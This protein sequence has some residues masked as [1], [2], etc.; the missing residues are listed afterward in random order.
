VSPAGLLRLPLVAVAFLTRVP[1]GRLVVAGPDDVARAAPLFPVVGGAVGAAA[2]LTADVLAG[3]LPAQAA[4]ALAVAVAALL[5]GAM[6]LDALA[7]TADALGGATRERA[8]E[9]LRDHAIGAFGATALVV[10]LL[11]D[12]A[13]LAGLGGAG[14]AALA[15]LAA[16]AAGRAVTLP[17]AATLPSARP[18]DGQGAVLAGLRPW[19]V[20]VGIAL[21]LA[22]ALPAGAAGLAAAAAAA[23]VCV[24]LGLFYRRWLGGVTGDLLGAAAKV[25][26]T[27]ALVAAL[28]VVR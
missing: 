8:L 1:V 28:A 14:D 26:E 10:V 27:A 21:A 9:I 24:V 11:V 5:T 19:Q 25:A 18:G 3:P 6:H 12:S 7:D 15:G 2:G 16:G 17:L 23:T 4:G 20:A 22:L 13:A